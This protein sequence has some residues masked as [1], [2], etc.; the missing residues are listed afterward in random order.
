M[1][2]IHRIPVAWHMLVHRKGRFVLSMLG[3]AF[4]VVIMFMEIGF[5]NGIN[6][7]QARLPTFLNADLVLLS[8]GRT[9][10]LE[11]DQL[12]RIR[13]QQ[14]LAFD[15]VVSAV[16]LYEGNQLVANPQTGLLQAIAVLAFPPH[17][18]PLKLKELLQYG[19]L[20]EIKG[21]ILFDRKSRDLYGAI[22]PGTPLNIGGQINTVVG[23]VEIG[24]SIKSD[25]Y[26]LMGD[27]TWDDSKSGADLV[28]M[29]LLKVSTGT[30]LA[31]LKQKL[32]DK[33]N[34]DVIVLTPEELRQ[35]EVDFTANATPAGGVFAIGLVIGFLIGMIICY[36]ILFNEIS[37]NMPQYATVKAV[38]FSKSYLTSLVMQQAVL[39]AVFGFLPGLGGGALLYH[40][41][42]HSTGILMFISPQRGLLIFVLTLFMC[43]A[44]GLLAVQKVLRAD[45]AEVF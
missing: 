17:T 12:N 9:T 16:P 42:E 43:V 4:S 40:V 28:S 25:G 29:A 5:F 7:S 27:Q 20:L 24:P 11:G 34:E 14:A 37:D 39:L 31:A 10:L 22:A 13:M 19:D 36:Q 26:I 41:I 35:R 6:D 21:N 15:G 18:Q 2:L 30:D 45:P 8:K 32:I 3:I 1:K 44:S 23:L 33:L 38:G